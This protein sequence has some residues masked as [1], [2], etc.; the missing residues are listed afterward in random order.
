[1][2]TGGEVGSFKPEPLIF[3]QAAERIQTAPEYI[4]FVGDNYHADILGAQAVGMTAV[5]LDPKG[6]WPEA[7]CIRVRSLS[8]ILEYLPQ[9]QSRVADG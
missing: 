5:L 8:E 3:L 4:M 1:V 9:R 2:L 6:L 7:E